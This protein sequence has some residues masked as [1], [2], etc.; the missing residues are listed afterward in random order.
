MQ[1]EGISEIGI[2]AQTLK[3]KP[4]ATPSHNTKIVEFL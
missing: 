4:I 1:D 2:I 3:H